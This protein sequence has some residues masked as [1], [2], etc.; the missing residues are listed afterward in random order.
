M[1]P[2]S[3]DTNIL[4]RNGYTVLTI[5]SLMSLSSPLSL[6]DLLVI[7]SC[8]SKRTRHTVARAR[9]TSCQSRDNAEYELNTQEIQYK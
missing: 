1:T 4:N 2:P 3:A 6:S 9:H 8:T 5:N 7:G